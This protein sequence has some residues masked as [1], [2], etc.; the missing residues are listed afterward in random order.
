MTPEEAHAVLSEASP[1]DVGKF[2]GAKAQ[3]ALGA[4]LF[5]EK[6]LSPLYNESEKLFVTV[7]QPVYVL[8]HECDIDPA[9][10]RPFNDYV[11]FCPVIPLPVFLKRYQAKWTD[12]QRLKSFL[13]NVACRTVGRLVYVPPAG[14]LLEFGGLVYLNNIDSTHVVAFEGLEPIAALSA[15]GLREL[16]MGLRHSL[17]REKADPVSLIPAASDSLR[18]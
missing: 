17:L 8:T 15:Y 6:V 13:A 9:N 1:I 7:R 4:G 18:R 11:S 10:A 14:G 5:Y 12:E 3:L 2:Y 16:D